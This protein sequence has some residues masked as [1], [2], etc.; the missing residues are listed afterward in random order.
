MSHGEA[1]SNSLGAEGLSS[2]ASASKLLTHYDNLKSRPDYDGFVTRSEG[3]D[4]AKGHPNLRS[5][6]ND[7]DYTKATKDDYLYLDASKMDF[8]DLSTRSY[9]AK[10]GVEKGVDLLGHVNLTSSRS[11]ST[12]YALGRTYMTLLNS[13]GAVRISNGSWNAYDWDYGGSTFR[14]CLINAERTLKKL[15]DS[16]GF[17]IKVYGTGQLNK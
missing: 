12:T 3:I 5:N 11:R 7:V 17:P 6:T 10:N 13:N 14:D 1:L 16:H 2:D 8:G 15:N 9:F 4:W